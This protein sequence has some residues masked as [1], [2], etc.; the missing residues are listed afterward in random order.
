VGYE[1]AFVD[2][3]FWSGPDEIKPELAKHS[4]KIVF[5]CDDGFNYLTKMC[6]T[7]MREAAFQMIRLAKQSGAVVLMSSSD[8]TDHPEMYLGCGADFVITGEVEQ[9]LLELVNHILR[10]PTD[11]SAIK[12]LIYLKDGKPARSAA[13]PNLKE[14]DELPDPAWDLLDIASYKKAWLERAGYFSMNVATTRGC[15]FHCN[16]CAKPIYGQRYYTRSPERVVNEI[17]GLVE[18]FG[19]THIWFCDDIFGLKP[20]WVQKFGEQLKSTLSFIISI[21]DELLVLGGIIA[22]VFV[23]NKIAAFVTAILTLVTAMKALRTAA[24]GAAIATAFATGG[25]SVGAA[26]AALA[27]IAATYGL[28]QLAGGSDLPTIPSAAKSNSNF[29]YGSGNPVYITVNAI[30]GE[31]AAR[32]VASVLNQSAAR[33]QGLLVGTTVGR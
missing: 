30:D 21:K 32:A 5:I 4:P 1:I 9:T 8:A 22:V 15:P 11:F 13:R 6:L 24:A 27:G 33:S 23:A 26:A 19:I 29:T 28:S 25:V 12:G 3:M 17:K 18:K 10:E 2:S 7:N 14:L 20:G 31:G 16:W